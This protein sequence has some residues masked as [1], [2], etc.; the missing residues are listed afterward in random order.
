M[1][2]L[3]SFAGLVGT[4]LKLYGWLHVAAFLLTW[5]NADRSNLIVFYVNRLTRP[6]WDWVRNHTSPAFSPFAPY[7]ALMLV[8]FG[9]I[10]VPGLIRSF[11]AIFF[12]ETEL[13]VG[14]INAIY[15]VA[16]GTFSILNS[17]IWFVFLLSIIWFILT[18]VN[19]PLNN[20]IVSSVMYLIE[21]LLTP[22]QRLLPRA[23]IDL[24][25]IALAVISYFISRSIVQM[26]F[27]L[28]SHLII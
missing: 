23:K 5:V 1:E 12:D 13:V 4:G 14:M 8:F 18:L 21:P 15:Y 6:L 17:V 3:I 10:V 16:L 7:L 20:P 25:P 28:Q 26:I 19:P 2:H 24:A 22:L 11:G 9:E 27:S